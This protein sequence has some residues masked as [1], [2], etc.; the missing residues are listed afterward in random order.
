MIA[1]LP[2]RILQ[3]ICLLSP[4][5]KVF[6]DSTSNPYHG[7][8]TFNSPNKRIENLYNIKQDSS[9]LE[10]KFQLHSRSVEQK[11]DS[12]KIC[13]L[14]G[15]EILPDVIVV[16]PST[17]C[18][19]LEQS[20]FETLTDEAD[21]ITNQKYFQNRCCDFS[22]LPPSYECET[23]VREEIFD[24][25]DPAVA[26]IGGANSTS[27]TLDVSAM[28]VYIA[29]KELDIQTSILDLFVQVTLTWKDPRLAWNILDPNTCVT[30]IQAKASK[31]PEET[32]I[33]VPSFDLKNRASSVHDMPSHDAQIQSDGTVTWSRLGPLGV[34]CTFIGL[35]RMPFDEVGCRLY[36]G[37]VSD[38]GALNY[39]MEPPTYYEGVDGFEFYDYKQ[40]YSEF[41]AIKERTQS[42][43]TVPWSKENFQVDLYFS[44]AT[45]YY[46]LFTLF[47]NILFAYMS[48]GQFALDADAGERLSYGVTILLI[49]VAQSIVTASFLPVCR[50]MLWIN[51]FNLVSMIFTLFGILETIIVFYITSTIMANN[52]SG[53][54]STKK[55][56]E[57]DEMDSLVSYAN[58][59]Q[60]GF[61]TKSD[62]QQDKMLVASDVEAT[63]IETTFDIVKEKHRESTSVIDLG[64]NSDEG[65]QYSKSS[66]NSK[67][68]CK[69]NRFM[70][71]FSVRPKDTSTLV[72][73]LDIICLALLPLSYTIFLIIMFTWNEAWD[74]K[75]EDYWLA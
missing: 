2:N 42:N 35:R 52:K 27:R 48:F 18:Q 45:S 36:F 39:I 14:L 8:S 70:R 49:L 34:L 4:W 28:I 59:S 75:P 33:W 63:D 58:Q 54:K 37:E 46:T 61:D 38:R 47:P 25:Y 43:Y 56:D 30:S 50:E 15:L 66:S 3:I 57:A 6:A 20:F 31:N 68:R 24:S 65:G 17:T 62:Q 69:N 1:N 19:E 44:R 53:E 29:V 12:C 32:E 23:T 10:S 67:N 72:R 9:G 74:D 26:P 13:S 64:K 40:S 51:T 16:G 22:S 5:C 11:S 7:F 55:N 73:K 71:I 41:L 21:C 60:E